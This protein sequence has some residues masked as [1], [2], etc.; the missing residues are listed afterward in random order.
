MTPFEA[1][2]SIP[3]TEDTPSSRYED[4]FEEPRNGIEQKIARDSEEFTGMIEHEKME[5]EDAARLMVSYYTKGASFEAL[6]DRD[7]ALAR[8]YAIIFLSKYKKRPMFSGYYDEPT[9]K[10]FNALKLVEGAKYIIDSTFYLANEG[11]TS[12][13]LEKF[14]PNRNTPNKNNR[15]AA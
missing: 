13:G 10:Q 15:R 5:I 3:R 7:K 11:Y 14:L 9:G 6:P 2:F 8:Q 1:R 12:K 4:P